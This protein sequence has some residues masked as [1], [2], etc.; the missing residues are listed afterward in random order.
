MIRRMRVPVELRRCYKLLNHG[1]TT[2]IASA[3]RGRTNVMAA[4]WV[5]PIDFE[6][7]LI[8]VVLASGTL[9]RELVDQSREFTLN[10][11][12]AAMV[13]AVH[14][15][16]RVSGNDVD[17]VAR[18]ELTTSPASRVSAPFVEGCVGWLECRVK[19]YPD[20]ETQL[21]LF[22]AEVTAAWADDRA[23]VD[24]EWRFGEES[25]RTIHHE[26]KGV[27]FTT[28]ERLAAREP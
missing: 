17:K 28:G 11:P 18:Y 7:P 1:P 3:A 10:L 8:A 6:P 9:T 13:D 23:F 4:D 5:M 2:L 21:D 14:A 12:T 22:V 27:F 19:A 25:L 24:G 15:V 26:S 20:M 16:G